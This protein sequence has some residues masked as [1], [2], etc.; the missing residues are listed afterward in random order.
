[1]YNTGVNVSKDD[2]IL[3]LST[4]SYE[5]ADGRLAIEAKRIK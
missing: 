5:I 4:C 1:M 2:S 3:T